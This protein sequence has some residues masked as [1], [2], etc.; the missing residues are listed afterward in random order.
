MEMVDLVRIYLH[1]TYGLVTREATSKE[2]SQQVVLD[3]R[4]QNLR[5][6]VKNLLERGDA[7]K[8]ARRIPERGEIEDLS[9]QIQTALEAEAR[10]PK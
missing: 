6:A 5:P 9:K 7:C 4:C 2:I 3:N 8:F 10:R 1:K